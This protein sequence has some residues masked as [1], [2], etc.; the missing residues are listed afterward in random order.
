MHPCG[1]ILW[2]WVVLG[3]IYGHSNFC[4]KFYSMIS[5]TLVT[6]LSSVGQ[7]ALL[8]RSVCCHLSSISRYCTVLY[9][10]VLYCT[11]LYCC[12]MSSI[13]RFDS[14]LLHSC[15][16]ALQQALLTR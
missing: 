13:S 11:V 10:T 8:R 4:H 6:S 2:S 7:L 12:H 9:C 15:L 16:Q 14:K 5:Q 3:L 1:Q